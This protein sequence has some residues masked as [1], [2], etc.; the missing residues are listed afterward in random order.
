[1]NFIRVVSAG[2][3]L[4]LIHVKGVR[5]DKVGFSRQLALLHER[6][7]NWYYSVTQFIENYQGLRL[8]MRD[9]LYQFA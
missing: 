6:N 7:L 1:M 3:L 4:P 2:G 8:I 5:N 9:L